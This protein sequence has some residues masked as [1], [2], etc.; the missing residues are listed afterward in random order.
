MSEVSNV[1]VRNLLYPGAKTKIYIHF[2]LWFGG[3]NHLDVG[4]NSSDPAVVTRQVAEMKQSGIDGAIVDWYGKD[5]PNVEKATQVAK[6]EA[7]RRGDFEIGI[8]FDNG[9]FKHMPSGVNANDYLIT[10]IKYA[11]ATYMASPMYMKAKDGRFLVS[12]FGMEGAPQA[13]DWN[14]IVSMFPEMA[15]LHRNKSGFPKPGAGAFSWLDSANSSAAYLTDFINSAQQSYPTKLAMCSTWK[16]FDDRQAAWSKNRVVDGRNGQL[17]L[18]TWAA[19]NAK[20]N[21]T[22][23]LD[24]LQLVTWNDYEEGTALE[25]GVENGVVLLATAKAG[26]C[27]VEVTAGNTATIDHY[28]ASV[29]GGPFVKLPGLELDLTQIEIEPGTYSVVFKA[30]GKGRVVNKLSNTVTAVARPVLVW[31]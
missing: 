14:K 3:K 19:L 23:Q 15:W 20:W 26:V 27:T 4:Y 9:M 21:A 16:G 24:M 18:E 2:M 10:Q 6:A 11:K 1:S 31:S 7:E 12:E 5:E 25:A 29:N 28:E 17:W 13:I 22:K 30:V 8:C